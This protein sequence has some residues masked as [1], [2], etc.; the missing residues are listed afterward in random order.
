MPKKKVDDDRLIAALLAN[1][2][3][4][5]AAA[6]AGVGKTTLYERRRD[7]AFVERLREAQRAALGD[8]TRF[9][10]Y[11]TG[12]AAAALLEIA[13]NTSE[14]SQVRVIAARTILE[15]A[16]KFTEIVDYAERL[17]AVERMTRE[18]RE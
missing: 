7:P 6:A 13:E 15:Q 8:T 3:M 4:G 9:L 14:N 2:T 18:G 1:P 16:A 5:A 12:S 11:S 10:Q 17:E